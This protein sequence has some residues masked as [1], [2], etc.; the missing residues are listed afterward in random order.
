[1]NHFIL[2]TRLC[3]CLFT[4][5]PFDAI[6]KTFKNRESSNSYSLAVKSL[7]FLCCLFFSLWKLPLNRF[8]K[9]LTIFAF[10]K[11][12]KGFFLLLLQLP[13][14]RF[15]HCCA[16]EGFSALNIFLA[17]L[18]K[19]NLQHHFLSLLEHFHRFKTSNQSQN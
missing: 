14:H 1:M 7:S 8:N 11:L 5:S 3:V 17:F 19:S 2:E 6:G 13:F 18:A 16:A 10:I 12:F 4:L 15:G 9:R